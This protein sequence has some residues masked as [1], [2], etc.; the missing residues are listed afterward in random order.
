MKVV[1]ES[2]RYDGPHA[3][4]DPERRRLVTGFDHRDWRYKVKT[5][6]GLT[7]YYRAGFCTY[8]AAYRSLQRNWPKV[9]VGMTRDPAN[10]QVRGPFLGGPGC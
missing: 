2:Y 10:L 5:E 6:T 1:I 9:L 7:V 8:D 3:N 4:W